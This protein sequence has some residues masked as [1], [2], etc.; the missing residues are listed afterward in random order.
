MKPDIK[1]IRARCDAATPGPWRWYVNEHSK[2]MNL[3]TDHSGQYYIMGFD[4]W[5]MQGAQPRFQVYE[6]YYGPVRDRKS[7]GMKKAIELSKWSQDYRHDD[8]II[9]HPDAELIAHAAADIPALLTYID[10]LEK[11]LEAAKADISQVAYASRVMP[12]VVC[13]N[14]HT[15]ECITGCMMLNSKFEWKGCKE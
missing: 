5:G 4:R 14:E 12:C 15:D 3:V 1:A 7:H 6:K 9:D 2:V 8:G 13:K 10:E 11:H